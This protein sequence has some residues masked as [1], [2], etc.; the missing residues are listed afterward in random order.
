VF[1]GYTYL[2]PVITNGGFTA[3]TAAAVGGQE[4]QKVLVPSVTT[5]KQAPNT[6]KNSFTLWTTLQATKRLQIG[7]GAFYTGRQYGGYADNTSATQD[8]AGVV[9]IHPATKTLFRQIPSYWRFDARVAYR[10]TDHIGLSV[11][12]QNQTN[13]TYFT[14]AYA[15]HYATI[16]PGRTVFGTVVVKF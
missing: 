6:A 13:E 16:A 14:Q 8:A 9:T 5:G 2:D 10:L 7:G 3:L 15:S 1:G 4:A 11:N 12:A